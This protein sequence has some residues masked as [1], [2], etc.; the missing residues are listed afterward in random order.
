MSNQNI[1]DNQIRTISSIINSLLSSGFII[2]Q[3]LEPI[4]SNDIMKQYPSYKKYIHKPD[5]L[6][7]RARKNN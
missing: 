3:M 7:I 1:Y 6:L 4:P 2:E 5:F